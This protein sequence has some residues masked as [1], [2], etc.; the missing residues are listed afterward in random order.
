MQA[1]GIFRAGS[2]VAVV[3]ALIATAN[4]ASPAATQV[5]LGAAAVIALAVTAGVKGRG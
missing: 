2:V 4:I 3:A 5:L 1:R